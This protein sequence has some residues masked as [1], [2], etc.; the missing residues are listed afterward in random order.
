M[1]PDDAVAGRDRDRDDRSDVQ[2]IDGLGALAE[3]LVGERV[4]RR[5]SS[6][7]GPVIFSR[8]ISLS[9]DASS[10]PMALLAICRPSPGRRVTI[11][12]R[13]RRRLR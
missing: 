11:S 4:R 10:V 5:A 6:R 13:W 7:P 12:A 3:V 1:A 2:R 8:T 9:F